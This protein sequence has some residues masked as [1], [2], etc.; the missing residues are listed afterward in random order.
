MSVKRNA[1][2][3]K[4]LSSCPKS[5]V[6]LIKITPDLLNAFQEVAHNLLY[7]DLPITNAEVKQLKKH[8]NQVRH[9]ANK[10]LSLKKG[11]KLL[12]S[13]TFI[14]TILKPAIRILYGAEV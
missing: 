7:S 14:K 8:K 4:F 2:V 5:N 11:Q 13:P 6:A 3:L 1:E 9:L 12:S 10:K